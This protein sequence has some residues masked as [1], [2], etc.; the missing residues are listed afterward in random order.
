M[1]ITEEFTNRSAGIGTGHADMLPHMQQL[2]DLAALCSCVVEFGTR[3][4]NSTSA[5]LAGLTSRGGGILYSYDMNPPSCSF[6]ADGAAQWKF[7]QAKTDE[8]GTIPDCDLLFVD[9]LHT[10][11][12]VR[13]ELKHAGAV[14]SYIA[15][16][17][18]N[19][20]G[21]SGEAGQPGIM[22]AIF[23]F[24]ARSPEWRVFAYHPS[25]WGLLVLKRSDL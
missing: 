20:F 6:E 22:P 21:F 13:A 17:D 15:L 10:E 5:I 14:R 2:H 11:A 24:L 23:D 18:V 8:L 4:G 1:T 3:T 7:T 25:A 19:M 16:H 9:T 12:Q